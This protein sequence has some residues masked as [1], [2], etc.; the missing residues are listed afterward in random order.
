[1]KF[2]QQARAPVRRMDLGR[3]VPLVDVSDSMCG[4][5]MEVA[6][7]LGILVSELAA[8]AFA[9]RVLT[10]ESRPSWFVLDAEE[11]VVAKVRKMQG[12]PWGG[13]TN[14]SAA[15]RQIL[16]ILVKMKLS[17][18]EIPDLIIFSDMQFDE[19][20]EV[21]AGS[22]KTHYQLLQS[23]FRKAGLTIC[24]QPY[25]VPRVIF[26]NLHGGTVGFPAQAN[27][28]TCRC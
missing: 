27:T 26:W 19:A 13:S 10:F 8:P 25:A 7:A 23:D 16:D 18:D 21:E 3:L 6:I 11:G 5:P 15:I 22:F 14:F 9:H 17:P 12:A 1:M 20:R 4:Q 24:G 2:H 28:P